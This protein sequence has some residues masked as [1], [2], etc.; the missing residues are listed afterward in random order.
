M[1]MPTLTIVLDRRLDDRVSRFSGWVV[2]NRA[3]ILRPL[4]GTLK[5]PLSGTRK[6]PMCSFKLNITQISPFSWISRRS[7]T[8]SIEQDIGSSL[9][10]AVLSNFMAWIWQRCITKS[11]A[12]VGTLAFSRDT[13][14]AR[15]PEVSTLSLLSEPLCVR[16][17]STGWIFIQKT[18]AENLI[19]L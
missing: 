19:H 7:N 11:V 17:R 5:E 14:S 2:K 10:I 8:A 15:H 1:T 16:A 9:K 3:T 12:L 6:R 4:Y 13:S 18:L